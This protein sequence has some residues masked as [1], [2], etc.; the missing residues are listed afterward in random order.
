MIGKSERIDVLNDKGYKILQDEKL[1]NFTMDA[2]LLSDFA[3]SSKKH[4]VLDIG[5]GNGVI[6]LLMHARYDNDEIVGVEINASNA[7]LA[8]KSVEM[9]CLSNSIKIIND[10]VKNLG[11]YYKNSYFDVVVSNP[12]YMSGGI[13][14]SEASKLIARHEVTLNFSELALVVSQF[15]KVGGSF[16]VIHR[17][18]RLV[19]IFYELRKNQLEP[20]EIRFVKPFKESLPNVVLI[21]AIRHGKP[22]LRYLRDLI[23]YKEQGVYTKEIL[24]IYEG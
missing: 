22:Q 4:K 16:Y 20:K 13:K 23:V 7:S 11:T 9:N 24:D 15:L 10:D 1:Y 21:K 8:K 14:P 19:D 17:P 12:P 18:N 2:V 6:P 5:T 3:K